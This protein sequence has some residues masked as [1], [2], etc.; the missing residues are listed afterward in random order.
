[1]SAKALGTYHGARSGP[2]GDT[3]E[4]LMPRDF[5]V[6]EKAWLEH[7]GSK[8][9][10]AIDVKR[11]TSEDHDE[12]DP[13]AKRRRDEAMAWVRAYTGTWALI[14]DIRANPRFGTKHFRLSDRQV[15]VII[16]A[17]DRDAARD[18]QREIDVEL[19]NADEYIAYVHG[20]RALGNAV[21]ETIVGPSPASREPVTEGMY[22]MPD[23]MIAKVQRAVH[24]SH[25]LYAKALNTD[26]GSFDYVPGLIR[27]LS[28][29]Q[30]MTVEEAK[31]FGLLYGRC[32]VCGRTLT[33]EKS[34]A[35]GIGPICA[36]KV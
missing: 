23:G 22:Q 18:A 9:L 8:P 5:N 30:R 14:L 2:P 29:D 31:A 3:T 19:R 11:P 35:D 32:I 26:T 10:P 6:W 25:N 33:D 7:L 36:A 28:A 13:E 24:G 4:Y 16:A 1:M 27:R 20:L 15:E 17:R 21:V 12:V 34:I